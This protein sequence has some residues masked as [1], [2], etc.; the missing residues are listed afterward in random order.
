MKLNIRKL[1]AAEI[2]KVSHLY[3]E[4]E[5][6]SFMEKRKEKIVAGIQDI[7]VLENENNIIG[8]VTIVYDDVHDGFTIKGQR[9][10]MEALRIE[11]DYQG[12][13]YGQHLINKVIEN[14]K[15][16]GYQEITIGV[17][18]DNLNAKHIYYKLGFTNYV[19]RQF[20]DKYAP[21]GYDVWLKKINEIK[22][23]DL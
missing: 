7:Y 19:C 1:D 10:Y 6:P 18:D 11:Q 20:G 14:I 9:V 5:N 4:P 17:E 3:D 23:V 2:N 15:N 8:E 16:Q 22:K 13:G 12:K 21:E